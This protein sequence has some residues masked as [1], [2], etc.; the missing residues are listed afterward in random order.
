MNIG[1]LRFGYATNSS[2]SHS[3]VI[4][5]DP[6]VVQQKEAESGG[7]GISFGWNDFVLTD[8]KSKMEYLASQMRDSLS[9]RLGER[10]ATLAVKDL[11]GNLIDVEGMG[12][13][14]HQSSIAFPFSRDFKVLDEE[15]AKAFIE[16]FKRPDLVVTGGNDNSDY[17]PTESIGTPC[18]KVDV[19]TELYGIPWA[20]KQNDG[21]WTL[22]VPSNG[23]KITFNF[24][25]SKN[26]PFQKSRT[27][28]LIDLKIT[29]YCDAGCKY[30]Y[31]DSTTKGKHA[32]YEY[33]SSLLYA[34]R[35][36]EVFEVAIGGGEPFKH[37][38][39]L[40]I[41]KLSREHGILPNISTRN[42]EWMTDIPSITTVDKCVG[43]VGFSCSNEDDVHA[44]LYHIEK[45]GLSNSKFVVHYVLGS[46]PIDEFKKMINL[47]DD[48]YLGILLLGYKDVGR[49]CNFNPYD[50]SQW[51]QCL[52][53]RWIEIGVDTCIAKEYKKELE[54]LGVSGLMYYEDEGKTSMYIDAVEKKVAKSSYE[55]NG[56]STDIGMFYGD[57][58]NGNFFNER[59]GEIFNGY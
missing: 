8:T 41:L 58:Y 29:D 43:K 19:P 39:I 12:D 6:A 16:F 34:L 7:W 17:D 9:E 38:D 59:L 21:W 11:F 22:F 20:K 24:D 33:I 26:K 13:V 37:P 10:I 23:T 25:E 36:L 55:K 56:D 46:S 30:C 15:F 40:N 54:N 53:N 45:S 51:A 57:C 32:S 28:D 1:N 2:S 27:P 50:N 42:L 18:R 35:D 52:K 3:I 47:I 31:Q 48:A 49:G 14:D 44:L 5:K 4:V